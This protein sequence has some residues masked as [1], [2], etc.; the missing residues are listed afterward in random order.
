[1]PRSI[2]IE[3]C[4]M[5]KVCKVLWDGTG[6]CCKP[7]RQFEL[8][9]ATDCRDDGKLPTLGNFKVDAIIGGRILGDFCVFSCFLM[10]QLGFIGF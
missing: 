9:I 10:F 3:Q 7:K 4:W 2:S 5:N 8:I 6:G 1:M